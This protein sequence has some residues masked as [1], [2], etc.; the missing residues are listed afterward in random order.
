MIYSSLTMRV[1]NS[2]NRLSIGLNKSSFMGKHVTLSVLR[3]KSL[4]PDSPELQLQANIRSRTI[5]RFWYYPIQMRKR[6][7]RT[8]AGICLL[9]LENG[10]LTI[11]RNQANRCLSNV[12]NFPN[13]KIPPQA[14]RLS[15]SKMTVKLP[16]PLKMAKFKRWLFQNWNSLSLKH[17][18]YQ[19]SQCK[20]RKRIN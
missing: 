8:L 11:L 14:N 12:W 6:K 5:A 13:K 19:W 4:R 18:T 7:K 1:W 10:K 20:T 3:K 2:L 16:K 9:R 17:Q 15:N